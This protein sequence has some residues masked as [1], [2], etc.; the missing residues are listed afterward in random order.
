MITVHVDGVDRRVTLAS[1]R[2]PRLGKR[3]TFPAAE[4]VLLASFLE[5]CFR[6]PL[7]A[8]TWIYCSTGGHLSF[9]SFRAESVG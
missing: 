9:G 4:C 3:G 2:A 8:M 5:F 1:I 6:G 7:I